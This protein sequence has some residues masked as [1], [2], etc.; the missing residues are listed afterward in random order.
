[1]EY[2]KHIRDL[3]MKLGI[4]RGP[5]GDTSLFPFS[6]DSGFM[7]DTTTEWNGGGGRVERDANSNYES[8]MF[9]LDEERRRFLIRKE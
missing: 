6:A 4:Q 7:G 9:R 8:V 5:S 3:E 2:R 1:V